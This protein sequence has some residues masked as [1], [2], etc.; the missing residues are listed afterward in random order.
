MGFNHGVD[1]YEMWTCE[2]VRIA[3]INDIFI[4]IFWFLETNHTFLIAASGNI[5]ASIPV[6]S[7]Q[8]LEQSDPY[9]ADGGRR[10]R[11]VRIVHAPKLTRTYASKLSSTHPIL[12]N[13]TVCRYKTFVSL[14]R[15][16]CLLPSVTSAPENEDDWLDG[17]QDGVSARVS[18]HQITE[19]EFLLC[20]LFC[21]A[22]ESKSYPGTSGR[23][24][25]LCPSPL[26]P[27]ATAPS[28]R[29]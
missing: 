18:K 5:H 24:P 4:F 6:L 7:R 23:Y 9:K 11:G 1:M 21:S 3:A 19:G 27:S 12:P 2:R 26:P 29:T 22:A 8:R 20:N 25:F 13:P 16:V 10:I 14:A 15:S 17:L 28:V